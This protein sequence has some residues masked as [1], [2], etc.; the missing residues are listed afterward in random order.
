MSLPIHK[1][2][3]IIFLS[4]HPR[5]PKLGL[6]AVAKEVKCDK[7]AVKYWLNRWK[8][9][10]DLTDLP[11]SGRPRET[12]QKQDERIVS[13]A[14]QEM[15]ATCGD[16]EDHLNKEGVMISESTVLRRL[17]EAEAKY[18]LPMSKPV[19]SE[20]QQKNRLKWARANKFTNWDR[21]I[22]SDE[23][24]VYM[25]RVTRRVSNL[26]G[27]KKVILR[28]KHP[29]IVNVWGCF[30]SKGFGHVFCFKENLDA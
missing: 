25:N 17:H 19:L 8:Q 6:K 27:N 28:V 26:P 29:E 1:G 4:C 7:K 11:R 15:F 2:Y 21:K 13:L 3:E 18:N 5:G 23:M 12:T 20:A 30:S 16:I 22:F 24:T 9:S 10:K 14:N